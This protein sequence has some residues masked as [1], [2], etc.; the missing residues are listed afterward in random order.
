MTARQYVPTVAELLDRLS[1]VQLKAWKIPA[2]RAAY[3]QEMRLILADVAAALT[4][5]PRTGAEVAQMLRAAMVCAQINSEIWHNES[6]VRAGPCA[7]D[8]DVLRRLRLTHGLNGIR[9]QAKNVIAQA[10]GERVDLKVDCLAA[11]FQAW[12]VDW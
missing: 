1:I 2:H 6:D 3:D 7:D 12:G 8:A 10:L 5:A 11:E 9:S 4:E